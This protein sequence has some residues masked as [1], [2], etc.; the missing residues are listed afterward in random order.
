MDSVDESR[1]VFRQSLRRAQS[2][3][4]ELLPEPE[5]EAEGAPIPNLTGVVDPWPMLDE[6]AIRGVIGDLVRAIEPHS[7]ADVVALLVQG[8]I[9]YGNTLKQSPYFSA[10]ADRHHMNLNAVLVGETAKGRKGTSW[11]YV[12]RVFAQVDPD[13]ANTRILNGL[14]SGEG[15][16]WAVRDEITKDEPVRE[17]GK[18]TG[19]CQT[20]V[21]D[22]GISDKRLLVL[23]S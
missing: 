13:W 7:E 23:E 10:E 18:P 6:R 5:T 11:G 4:A 8:L 1:N 19:E 14:S 21:V 20:I 15:L 9:A 3:L 12:R 16:I 2:A 17:K 22:R